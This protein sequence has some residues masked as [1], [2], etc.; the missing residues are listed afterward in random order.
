MPPKSSVKPR[1]KKSKPRALH[2]EPSLW[3]KLTHT[4]TAEWRVITRAAA[5]V[6]ATELNMGTVRTLLRHPSFAIGVVFVMWGA[7]VPLTKLALFEMGPASFLFLRM[8]IASVAL[9]PF[10]LRYRQTFTMKEELSLF[11]SAIIG[12]A[13][14]IYLIYLALP[15]VSSIN[16]PVINA[17]SPFI[18]VLLARMFLGEKI[19]KN[20]YFGMAFG[21]AGV[22]VITLVPLWL[23]RDSVLGIYSATRFSSFYGDLI[24]F[25]SAFFGTIGTLLIKPIRHIPGYIITFWQCAITAVAVLP[26][27]ISEVPSTFVPTMS[28][29]VLVALAYTG[30]FSTVIGYSLFNQ[31]L[32]KVQASD[33]ALLSYLSPIGAL[34]LGIPLLH[35]IP[36]MWFIIGA[37]FVLYG[38]WIAEGRMRRKANA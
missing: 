6:L 23:N 38:V 11:F 30:I 12:M 24:I 8:V 4:L 21:L 37:A 9:F 36:D 33:I 29:M 16:V 32:H 3:G 18:L 7:S 17:L 22:M 34:M 28:P 20:K 2:R 35:E 19:K 10:A 26:I 25:I 13:I 1:P 5:P 31:E 27:A 15:S 14:H